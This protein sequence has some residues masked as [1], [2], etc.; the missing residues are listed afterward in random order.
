[1]ST[2]EDPQQPADAGSGSFKR[3][4]TAWDV[5]VSLEK[6][7]SWDVLEQFMQEFPDENS[8]LGLGPG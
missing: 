1:M 5:D 8:M 7:V 6:L 3:A 2:T 4:R